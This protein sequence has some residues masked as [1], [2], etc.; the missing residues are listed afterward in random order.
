MRDMNLGTHC[1][2]SRGYYRKI[3]KWRKEDTKNARDCIPSPWEGYGN[4]WEQELLVQKAMKTQSSSS[5]S[6][7]TWDTPFNRVL[8]K[9]LGNDFGKKPETGRV[10]GAGNGDR[11]DYYYNESKG[12]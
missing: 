2:G 5:Q 6:S 10:V 1:L 7:A 9:V 8:N 11:W 12:V 4:Q 3:P